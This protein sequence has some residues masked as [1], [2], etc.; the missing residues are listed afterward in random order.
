MKAV[1]RGHDNCV[2]LLLTRGAQVNERN[3]VGT[4]NVP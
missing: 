1:L 4:F 2:Q 3:N